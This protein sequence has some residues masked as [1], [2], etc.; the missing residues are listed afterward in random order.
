MCKSENLYVFLDL[1]HTP[2][3][4]DFRYE[5]DTDQPIVYFPLKVAQCEICGLTQLT[6]VVD[7]SLLFQCDYPYESSTTKTG[8][9][10]WDNYA[11]DVKGK[12]FF[13]DGDLVVDIG[14][15]VGTLL[16]SFASQ[17]AKVQG[18]DPAPNIVEIANKN[19]VDTICSFINMEAAKQV[20]SS[21]GKAKVVTGT[22]VFAHVDN[23]DE[24]VSSVQHMLDEDGVFVFESPYFVNLL[25][26]NQYDTVYHE[27]LS[28]ISIRPLVD[29][30]EKFGLEIFDVVESKIHGGSIRVYVG[31]KGAHVVSEELG[32]L[33]THESEMK[34]YDKDTLDDFSQRVIKNRKDL[35]VLVDGLLAEGNKLAA[36]SAPA[37]GMTLLNYCGI[38]KDD[39]MF[40]TEKS[41]LKTGRYTP[42]THIPVVDDDVLL[43]K[44]PDFVIIL[45]WNF[46][47]E[48]MENLS[49]YKNRGGKFIVPIPTPV[50]I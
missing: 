29:F 36:V 18:I 11:S 42:G 1:G 19:G 38:N 6:H 23:L 27:H 4:D 24:F 39:L 32:R 15:N 44:M 48:I 22:N 43:D 31:Y 2:P 47:A 50:I 35:R 34:V 25:R 45:A 30:F 49:E 17:G 46:A 7:P 26:E 21:K 41:K 40:V 28:Y 9:I 5:S 33:L 13:Y 37:K 20:V 8:K 3:A 12:G 14:S 10:H 16:E